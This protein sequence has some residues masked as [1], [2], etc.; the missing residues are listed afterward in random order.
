MLNP[1]TTLVS[2]IGISALAIWSILSIKRHPTVAFGILIFFV[3]HSM[4]STVL[5]LEIAHEHRNYFP[6]FGL[7]FAAA[8]WFLDPLTHGKG[9]LARRVVVSCFILMMAGIT[10]LRANDWSDEAR[11]KAKEVKYHPNSVRAN[12]DM[13]SLYVSLHPSSQAQ[14]EEFYK[15]AYA[16]YTK[17][18]TIS[19]SD[20][21]GLLGL[22]VLNT[23]YSVP[24]EKSWLPDLV[25]RIEDVPFSP[26]T[27]NFI[28]QLMQCPQEPTCK[29]APEIVEALIQAALRNPTLHGKSR[30]Q[31]LFAW[32]QFLLKVKRQPEAAAAAAYEAYA[33]FPH[34]I[35]SH[36]VLIVALIYTNKLSEAQTQIEKARKVDKRQLRASLLAN[37]EKLV[38][39]RQRARQ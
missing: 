3:G 11:L 14:E 15:I 38:K 21:T 39:A 12:T 1:A 7:L 4:E 17:A 5:P 32:S 26:V 35:D 10:L 8:F 27:S 36:I 18:L 23:R 30:S 24:L 19:S 28:V 37:L 16:H 34:D 25:K 29:I 2:A 9:R 13:A 33:S 31:I 22:I 20:T 6:I